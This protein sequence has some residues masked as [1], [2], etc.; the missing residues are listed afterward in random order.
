MKS[1]AFWTSLTGEDIITSMIRTLWKVLSEVKMKIRKKEISEVSNKKY[2]NIIKTPSW[3]RTS[4]A[5]RYK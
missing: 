3:I 4:F 5:W 1:S 2:S